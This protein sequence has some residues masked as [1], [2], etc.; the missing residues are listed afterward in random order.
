[1]DY[2]KKYDSLKDMKCT[3]TVKT[4]LLGE[5]DVKKTF[6]A[7]KKPSKY[8][9]EDENILRIVNG[10]NI[11]VYNKKTESFKTANV[12]ETNENEFEMD[13]GGIVNNILEKNKAEYIGDEMIE[14]RNC[15]VFELTP[16][17]KISE[18][19]EAFEQ[20]IWVDK[21]FWYPLKIK[22]ENMTLEYSDLEFNSDLDDSLF[23][24]DDK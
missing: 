19:T 15:L 8:R 1:M 4:D 17:E 6:F 18:E 11:T 9:T 23:E 14:G 10:D 5:T 2:L 20:R 3:I 7:M 16:K 12:G 22:L 24:F 21:E 13:Y